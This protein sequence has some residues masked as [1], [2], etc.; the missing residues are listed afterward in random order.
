M[1]TSLFQKAVDKLSKF[2]DLHSADIDEGH[3]LV[4]CLIVLGHARKAILSEPSLEEDAPGRPPLTLS[5]KKLAIELAALYHDVSDNKFFPNDHNYENVS[6]ILVE[7]E[8]DQTITDYVIFMISLVSCSKNGNEIVSPEWL[9]IPRWSDR[10]EAMGKIGIKRAYIYTITTNRP[11]YLGDTPRA[12]NKEEL[13][14][15]A[16]A[17]RFSRYKGVSRS[18][19]D[20]FYDKILHLHNMPTSNSYFLNEALKRQ[21]ILV[22]FC[23]QFGIDGGIDPTNWY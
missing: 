5:Q 3:N 7:L 22:D 6:N 4:H 1:D 11:L 19:M 20:H 17:D 13:A 23:I 8:I 2:I 14:A 10:L 9:L 15:I 16:T 12:T 21:Q 18:F